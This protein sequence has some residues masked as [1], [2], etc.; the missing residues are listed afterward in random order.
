MILKNLTILR[1]HGGKD[2]MWIKRKYSSRL[3][4]TIGRYMFVAGIASAVIVITSL[5]FLQTFNTEDIIG[6]SK[7][8]RVVDNKVLELQMYIDEKKLKSDDIN[9]ILDWNRSNDSF[10]FLLLK[11]DVVIYDS[12]KWL[13]VLKDMGDSKS[14]L[15]TYSLKFSNNSLKLKAISY[16]RL[17]NYDLTASIL[18]ASAYVIFII[19]LQALLK[20]KIYYISEIEERVRAI[21]S[22]DLEKEI[23]VRGR[24][25]LTSLAYTVNS[26]ALTI[27]EQ[28]T[29]EQQLKK[30]KSELI[31]ALSHDIRTPLTTAICYLDLLA[32]NKIDSEEKKRQYIEHI[33]NKTYLIKD[34]TDDLFD[35]SLSSNQSI[36]FN[37]EVLRGRE[38][39][40]Q[41]LSDTIFTLENENF[42]VKFDDNMTEEFKINVDVNQ[43]I[44][45]FDNLSS[46]IIKYADSYYPICIDIDKKEN[47]LEVTQVNQIRQHPT[48][49]SYGL[50]VNT[51][52]NIIE[53]HGGE[54]SSQ[55]ENGLFTIKIILPLHQDSDKI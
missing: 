25:E 32:G 44:R 42:T 52:K 29:I 5:A 24:D 28:E 36:H 9:E 48:G 46:N 16:Y 38:M 51:S 18:N 10:F 34:L 45:V 50:G 53:R 22:G 31:S 41:L 11:D 2:I 7:Y 1:Q 27:K 14:N 4:S 30:E 20:K 13:R 19:I 49:K 17:R 47:T 3:G 35:N 15:P 21:E 43:M 12:S 23:P 26:M 54:M 40:S 6:N 55:I 39:F 37:F 8:Q 33:R